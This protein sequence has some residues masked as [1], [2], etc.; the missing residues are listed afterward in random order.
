MDAESLS[1]LEFPQVL[2]LIGEFAHSSVG[3]AEIA[4]LTPSFARKRIE[5]RLAL[6]KECVHYTHQ[7]GRIEF[8]AL[9]DPRPILQSLSTQREGIDPV[10]FVTLFRILT[11]SQ[12]VQDQLQ[13]S[14]DANCL[15]YLR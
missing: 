4:S 7:Q 12:E 1:L 11:L 14:L 6:L 2:K 15:D 8:A 5:D 13:R 10:E 9:E 3:K